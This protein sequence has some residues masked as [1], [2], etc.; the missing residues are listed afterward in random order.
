MLSP[1][2]YLAIRS[3][4]LKH[5]WKPRGTLS[6]HP[7]GDQAISCS[8]AR[9]L[10]L[11]ALSAGSPGGRSGQT[12]R[13]SLPGRGEGAQAGLHWGWERCVGV[14]GG[15]VTVGRWPW[16]R[17][18]PRSPSSAGAQCHDIAL[19]PRSCGAWYH[20]RH[21]SCTFGLNHTVPK[22]CSGEHSAGHWGGCGGGI[23]AVPLRCGGYR[24]AR[25][26]GAVQRPHPS[27][28]RRAGRGNIFD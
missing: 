2:T 28:R 9:F 11:R 6:P 12:P 18:V 19:T 13:V 17:G 10:H 5:P 14:H 4:R 27:A 8:P 21:I 20:P 22:A 24:E 3:Q 26:S 1:Q 23:T 7:P 15:S 16:A 25:S